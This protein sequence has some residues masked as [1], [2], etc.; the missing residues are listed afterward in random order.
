M[1]RNFSNRVL[2]A[3]STKFKEKY[4]DS[5]TKKSQNYEKARKN[6]VKNIMKREIISENSVKIHA[7]FITFFGCGKFKY[8]PGSFT[9]FVSVVIWFLTTAM[10]FRTQFPTSQE[11]FLWLGI[12]FVLFIY[13][14]LYI[15]LYSRNFEREDHPTIV[16]DEVVGQILVLCLT[17]PLIK[18]YYFIEESFLSKLIMC[19][20]IFSCFVFFR[21]FDIVKPSFIGWIDR[22]MKSSFGIMFDDLVSGLAAAAVNF[23]IF[24]IYENAIWQLHS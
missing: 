4:G 23:A 16:I 5:F 22:N 21:F 8:G 19:A 24:F 9:S 18:K 11:L 3:L 20:H 15:P 1:F 13:G 17:Y 7:I 12:C 2:N 14:V 6:M 10:F